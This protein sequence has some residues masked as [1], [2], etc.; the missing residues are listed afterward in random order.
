MRIN[1]RIVM[2]AVSSWVPDAR[3]RTSD[4]LRAGRLS[5]RDAAQSGYDELP[6]S[7][8]LAAPQM[9]VLA[10]AG[11]LRDCGVAAAQINMLIHSWIHYQGHDFWS[12]AHYIAGALKMVAAQ[13]V[14]L[15]QMCNGGAAAVEA[16]T[17]RL[18]S[19]HT[20]RGVLVT[21]ADR[22]AQPGFDRWQADY[23]VVYGDGATAAVLTHAAYA[24]AHDGL[25]LLSIA[26]VAASELEQMHRGDDVFGVA[27][28]SISTAVDVRRT[29]KA[30][31]ST[32]GTQAFQQV[33]IDRVEQVLSQALAEA[34][35]LPDDPQVRL[36]ALPRLG[37]AALD[38]IY[39]P[40]VS[41]VLPAPT[42]DFGR[43][44]GHLGAG[45]VLANLAAVLD[46]DLLAP[47]EVGVALSAGA[48]FTWSCL[49][50]R[51]RA[52]AARTS[53]APPR[54]AATPASAHHLRG[55]ST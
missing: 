40:A 35:L 31:L 45:D 27:P 32:A 9:A 44:T 29:K 54:L 48:G 38:D 25:E 50:V 46:E 10:A 7:E 21:T 41:A 53:S 47:G 5:E 36:V 11:A 6:V 13:P 52:L 22:F 42:R 12:P 30:Y 49:I 26:T 14:G 1:G 34:D 28:G 23:G 19:D 2:T 18:L 51:R 20:V 16:A 37:T 15:Q 43:C 33:V 4:A 55:T 24:D 8:D 17:A 3:E 39:R